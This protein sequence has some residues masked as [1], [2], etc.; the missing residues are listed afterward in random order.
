MGIRSTGSWGG[1]ETE[2][3]VTTDYAEAQLAF[4]Q[5]LR[6]CL[7]GKAG[8]VSAPATDQRRLL[9]ACLVVVSGQLPWAQGP[10]NAGRTTRPS[11]RPQSAATT[12]PSQSALLRATLSVKKSV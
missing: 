9:L 6:A 8:W 3:L 10:Q 2:L 4:L 5:S 11:S 1:L 7:L 12:L